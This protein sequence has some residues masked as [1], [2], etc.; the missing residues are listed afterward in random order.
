MFGFGGFEL[1]YEGIVFFPCKAQFKDLN[2]SKSLI[3]LQVISCS[4]IAMY[5]RTLV[6]LLSTKSSVGVSW[7]WDE[8]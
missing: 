4:T 3:S 8:F 5:C 2:L 7:L 6:R 1:Q